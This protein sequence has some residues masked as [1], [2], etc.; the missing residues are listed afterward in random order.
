MITFLD[1][2]NGAFSQAASLTTR[3]ECTLPL[4]TILTGTTFPKHFRVL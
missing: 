4:I 3:L 1:W 2:I